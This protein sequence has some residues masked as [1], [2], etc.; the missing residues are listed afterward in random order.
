MGADSPQLRDKNGVSHDLR[1]IVMDKK[2]LKM[3]LVDCAEALYEKLAGE[4]EGETA[5]EII[6]SEFGEHFEFRDTQW[7][8]DDLCEINFEIDI[9]VD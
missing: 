8:K 2:E 4:A 3:Y 6:I 5:N 1:E 7:I 9:N